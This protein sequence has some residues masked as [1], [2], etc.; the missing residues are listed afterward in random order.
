M[1]LH[2]NDEF[3]SENHQFWLQDAGFS[4]KTDE[5]CIKKRM[6]NLQSRDGG[7]ITDPVSQFFRSGNEENQRFWALTNDDDFGATR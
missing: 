3:W 2:Q 6:M 7:I 4:I 1:I 5:F